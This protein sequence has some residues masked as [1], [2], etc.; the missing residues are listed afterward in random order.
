MSIHKKSE[1]VFEVRWREGGRQKSLRVHGSHELAR[2]IERKKMSIRDEN[3]HLDVKREVNLR[4]SALID[5]YWMQYGIKKRSADREKSILEG[6]RSELGKTFVREVDGN[7]VSH[8]YEN[9]TAVHEL[10]PGTAVRHFNVMHHM[11]KKAATIWTKDTGI[12]RNPADQVEVKRPDDQRDR[13][14]SEDEL[15]RLKV[16]LD[17]K[18]YRKGTKEFNK[19]FCRLRMIVLIAV[20]TGMR[21]SEIFGLLWSDVM[22]SEGLL[23]VRA[24]LKGGKMRYVPMPPELADELRRFMPQPANNV[25]YI[26]GNNH[27]RIFP[28]K[29]GAKGERQRVEGSFEDLLE[30]AGIEDFRF[31]DL[32]HTFASWYMM[33]GGDLYEL[34]KILGHSNIKMTE[35]YAKLARQHIARTSG[36]ARELWKI[37][38]PQCANAANVG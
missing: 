31:H 5:R 23:A 22:Y 26:A 9:L 11:M 32:R 12:D 13:Y 10:S 8:W 17:E 36:T 18:I 27:E 6:I 14:L 1:G 7:A 19:T 30:R 3:R 2:K 24:K 25:L 33:N 34:A 37:L 16:A 29:D 35:R 21:M 15:R 28:P 38:E 20:T 4:M